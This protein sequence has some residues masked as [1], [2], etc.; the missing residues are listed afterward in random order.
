MLWLTMSG[1]DFSLTSLSGFPGPAAISSF[2]TPVVMDQDGGGGGGGRPGN[3]D[4]DIVDYD[5]ERDLCKQFLR[6]FTLAGDIARKYMR[7]LQAVAD[8][9]QSNV[10]IEMDDLQQ[11]MPELAERWVV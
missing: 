1:T 4:L 3:A 2:T 10:E 11:Y 8:R 7:V 5:S 6:D 9:D